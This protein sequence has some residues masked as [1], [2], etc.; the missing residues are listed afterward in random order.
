[1]MDE[2]LDDRPVVDVVEVEAHRVVP[3]QVAAPGDLPQAG[4]AGADVEAPLDV[5]RVAPHLGRQ[6]RA[7][8]D[9]AHVAGDDV[10]QLRQ[11]VDGVAAHEARRRA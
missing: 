5:G 7:G 2:V 3:R 9:E 8:T 1:M 10:D 11:L 4:H 6:G